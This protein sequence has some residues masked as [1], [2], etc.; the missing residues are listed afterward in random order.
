MP[1]E[2][3]YCAFFFP[4]FQNKREKKKKDGRKKFHR[5]ISNKSLQSI[6]INKAVNLDNIISKLYIIEFI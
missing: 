3:Y 2:Q 1:K 5:F 6:H 4:P